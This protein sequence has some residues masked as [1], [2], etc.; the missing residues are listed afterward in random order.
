[1]NGGTLAGTTVT[2]QGDILDNANVTFDQSTTGTYSDTISGSGSVTKAGS[3]TVTL[4]GDNGY[5]G[6]TIIT[7]GSLHGT[8]VS[9]QG[10]IHL[11]ANTANVT[12]DQTVP[13]SYTKNITGSGS[14]TK[15]GGGT[16]T[17]LGSNDYTGGTTVSG[18]TLAG[19]TVSL[20]GDISVAAGAHVELD[21]SAPGTFVGEITGG[22][23]LIKDGTGTVTL[24]GTNDYTGGTTVSGGTLQGTTSSLQGDITAASGAVVAFAQV[25]N[26]SYDGELSGNGKLSKSGA[27]ILT[28][29]GTSSYEGG[30]D[31]TGGGL[32]ISSDA[33]LGNGGTVTM[34]ANTSLA[35]TASGTYTHAIK[36]TGDPNFIVGSGVSVTQSGEIDDGGGTPGVVEV[37][38]GGSFNPTNAANGYS[39]GTIVT[40]NSTVRIA[41]DHALGASTG[42]LTLGDDT[43]AGTLVVTA[44]LSSTRDVTLEA[45]GGTIAPDAG[46]TAS[47]GGVITGEGELTKTDDGTLVLTGANDYSGGTNLFGGVLRGTTDEP[48]G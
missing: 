48:A 6:G 45:G 15:A 12:F 46:V 44:T 47:L 1:M 21:Q 31:V 20:E 27:G 28:L 10:D 39:G 5:T 16:L 33:N 19:T 14:L 7:G 23:S 34:A 42:D 40:E 3:G 25:A 17:L 2:L 30:T 4:L 9:L 35:F 32:S 11:D 22:G 8:T 37:S 18:G 29:T 24:N 41:N 43:T 13:G 38:G 26:G 36:V